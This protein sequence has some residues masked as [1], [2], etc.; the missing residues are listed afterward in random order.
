MSEGG[1]EK[2]EAVAY[3]GMFFFGRRGSTNSVEDRKN[4]DLGAVAP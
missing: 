4:G 2:S 1:T 3:L